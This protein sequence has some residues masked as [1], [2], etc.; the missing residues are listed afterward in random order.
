MKYHMRGIMVGRMRPQIF[1]PFA[2]T[3]FG[4]QRKAGAEIRVVNANISLYIEPEHR[5][6]VEGIHVYY[7]I[8]L[9]INEQENV[10]NRTDEY[11][12]LRL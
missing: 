3:P 6:S 4:G 1:M 11:P 5:F 2:L 10:V 12:S 8:Y 7:E 9:D